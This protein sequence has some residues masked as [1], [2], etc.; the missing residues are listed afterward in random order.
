MLRFPTIVVD[1]FFSDPDVVREYGLSLN[2]FP[3]AGNYPGKRSKNLTEVNKKFANEVLRKIFSLYWEDTSKIRSGFCSLFFQKIPP[4]SENETDFRNLGWI[5][6]DSVRERNKLAGVLYLTPDARLE[7]GTTVY[8]IKKELEDSPF[9][10][11]AQKKVRESK[12]FLFT[13]KD[14][15]FTKDGLETIKTNMKEWN[16]CFE[17]VTQV[18]NVYNRSIAFDGN[19]WHGAN[20]Y[21]TG[22]QERLT[23][24]YFIDNVKG[25]T[26]P[27]DRVVKDNLT[28]IINATTKATI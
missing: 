28:E 24:V 19:E 18:S 9:D 1:K 27:K 22:E 16:S 10:P 4:F 6:R 23:I 20:N 7:S 15:S 8:K 13:E 11:V 17:A 14:E 25:A 3:T 26:L 21:Y 5:H 2:Y 12:N